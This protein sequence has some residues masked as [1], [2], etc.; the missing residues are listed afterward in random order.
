MK[1]CRALNYMHNVVGVCHRDIKPQN[2]LVWYGK[3]DCCGRW[4]FLWNKSISISGVSSKISDVSQVNP[5][6]HQLKICDFGSAKILV[7]ETFVC[8]PGYVHLSSRVSLLTSISK[9]AVARRTEHIL[10]MLKILQGSGAYFWGNGIHD[11]YRYVVCWLR[12]GGTSFRK[13]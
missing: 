5:H 1:I 3:I 2:L 6:T 13:C 7:R 12:L 4:Q 10:Y 8:A 9:I 11:C